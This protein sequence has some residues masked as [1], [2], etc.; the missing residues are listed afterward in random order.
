MTRRFRKTFF[1]LAVLF[2]IPACLSM[3]GSVLDSLV[4][5]FDKNSDE[6][7]CGCKDAACCCGAPCCAPK[8][9]IAAE[10]SCCGTSEIDHAPVEET[11]R[12]LQMA[13][14]ASCTCGGNH[15]EHNL[16]LN[17]PQYLTALN[18]TTFWLPAYSKNTYFFQNWASIP[19][20][21]PEQIPKDF[22][23]S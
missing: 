21:P 2:Y 20:L 13:W 11:A 8:T 10:S 19:L 9:E 23:Y 12:G 5:D 22:L 3:S 4:T 6:F 1:V 14:K 15:A 17:D 18:G 7:I 16:L